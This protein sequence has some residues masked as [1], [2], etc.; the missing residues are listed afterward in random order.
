MVLKRL[1]HIF[2]MYA[3]QLYR[4]FLKRLLHVFS[5]Y[6]VQLYRMLKYSVRQRVFMVLCPLISYYIASYIKHMF[7]I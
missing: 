3:V 2:S 6:A 4:M 1:L 7:Y 5:M